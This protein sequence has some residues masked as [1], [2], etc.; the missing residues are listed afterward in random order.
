LIRSHATHCTV[1]ILCLWLPAKGALAAPSGA[2][3]LS[4]CRHALSS[5][6]AGTEGQMC[7]WYVTPCD[8]EAVRKPGAPRVCL[9]ESVATEPLA[10]EVV[11]GLEAQPEL[12]LLDADIAAAKILSRIYPCPDPLP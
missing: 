11:N 4:A 1:L 5:K 2:D 3:L 10:R 12:Q 9:P 8:C 6:F 7:I